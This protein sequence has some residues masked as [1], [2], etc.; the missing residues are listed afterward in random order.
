MSS[1]LKIIATFAGSHVANTALSRLRD[2]RIAAFLTG[3]R[4]TTFSKKSGGLL[5][6][7][8]IADRI[9]EDYPLNT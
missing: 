8:A 2:A 4:E 5:A 9:L 6:R 1:Y 7:Q 3:E